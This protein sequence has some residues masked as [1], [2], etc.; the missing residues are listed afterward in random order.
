M[1]WQ[2]PIIT[3]GNYSSAR[4]VKIGTEQIKIFKKR[5]NPIITGFQ[6]L[7]KD[8]RI[9]TLERGGSD[10]SAIMLAKFLKQ[11]DVLFILMLRE[12]IQLIQI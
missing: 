5:W 4:I 10:A 9:T 3:R 8:N 1:S 12:F 7:N 2:I 11:K 6:G